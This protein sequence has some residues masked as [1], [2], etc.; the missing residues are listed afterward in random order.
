[1][2]EAGHQRASQY[3]ESHRASSLVL[4]WVDTEQICLRICEQSC[5]GR[6]WRL[7]VFLVTPLD[8]QVHV[9]GVCIVGRIEGG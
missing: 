9:S 3:H 4:R 6:D 2:A 5:T 7:T 1:M 8:V